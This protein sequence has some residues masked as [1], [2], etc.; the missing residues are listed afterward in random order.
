MLNLSLGA[1]CFGGELKPEKLKG[2]D[3][4]AV[5]MMRSRLKSQDFEERD[6]DHLPIP[7]ILPE[8]IDR[9]CDNIRKLS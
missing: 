2:F 6:D 7:E 1:H 5:R 8:A 9:L 4:F 3:K